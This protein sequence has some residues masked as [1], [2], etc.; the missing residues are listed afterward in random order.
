MGVKC[1]KGCCAS[2]Y[3]DSPQH[4]RRLKTTEEQA[5]IN[6]TTVA[7]SPTTMQVFFQTYLNP[8]T[9]NDS[10]TIIPE[11]TS[12]MP[13]SLHNNNSDSTR[14][15]Y[16]YFAQTQTPQHTQAILQHQGSYH[17]PIDPHSMFHFNAGGGGG[18]NQSY[19][20]VISDHSAHTNPHNTGYH[21]FGAISQHSL[22]QQLSQPTLKNTNESKETNHSY[23]SLINNDN[24]RTLELKNTDEINLQTHLHSTMMD[25]SNLNNQSFLNVDTIN[26]NNMGYKSPF[27]T[28][29]PP[30][31]INDTISFV[32]HELYLK[33]CHVLYVFCVCSELIALPMS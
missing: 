13:Y 23:H 28:P 2:S 20:S 24:N 1:S 14:Y 25:D 12:H 33:E 15:N 26:N 10:T 8:T 19:H 11:N 6:T 31:D 17:T 5:L 22:Q 32:L 4:I 7:P 30:P 16:N 21:S 3:S 27:D 29:P 18:G 9:N